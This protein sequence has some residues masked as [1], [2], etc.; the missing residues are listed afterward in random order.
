MLEIKT[1][2]KYFALLKKLFHNTD[3]VETNGALIR[4]DSLLPACGKNRRINQQS[5]T[6]KD[7]KIQL[8]AKIMTP[9]EWIKELKATA[10]DEVKTYIRICDGLK[11]DSEQVRINLLCAVDCVRKNQKIIDKYIDSRGQASKTS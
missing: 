2:K 8:G 1:K 10:W 9:A 3:L 6:D 4:C 5:L 11:P 7:S